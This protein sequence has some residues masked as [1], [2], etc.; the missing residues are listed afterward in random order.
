MLLK[1]GETC[2]RVERAQRVRVLIDMQAYFSALKCSMQ[3]A[4]HSLLLLGWAFD[5][6]TCLEPDPDGS[7]PV[8]DE[9]GPFIRNLGV[10][11]PDLDIRVLIWKS[12][13]PIAASQHF[14]PH[15]AR[16]CFDTTP[17]AF[18]LDE[19]VPLGACHHQKVVTIDDRVAFSGG[20]D[21]CV[22]RFDTPI[23]PDTDPRRIMPMDHKEHAPRHETM[24]VVD[25]AAAAA[26]ADLSR[27]RWRHA[28]DVRV[29]RP[30]PV[31][32]DPWPAD[33]EPELVDVP[34]G[35]SR[36]LPAWRGEPEVRESERLHLLSIAA[37][38]RCIYLENQ[39]IASPVIG[40]ALA[41][42]LAEPDGPEVVIISTEHAPSWFDKMTM[43]K[44][45]GAL[46]QQLQRADAHDRLHAFCP[47]TLGGKVIIVHS[48]V[49]VIDDCLL[50]VGSTNLNNRSL[51][52]D[53][54]V[55]L[56]FE[57]ETAEH[58]QAISRFLARTVGHFLGRTAEEMHEAVGGAGSLAR[59]IE[60]L[61]DGPRRRLRRIG[62]VRLGPLAT[63]IATYHLG[64]PAGVADAWRPWKR[65]RALH[66]DLRR[67]SPPPLPPLLTQS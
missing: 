19:T 41:A 23:H 66:K 65:R 58:R 64:D 27:E 62:P 60:R 55:D 49:S 32:H 30:P 1:P 16:K 26:L 43:D 5:P 31:A 46:L 36:T 45:R 47:E 54:E 44:T 20:G 18:R 4:Q 13:L 22:D 35:I 14:F 7:G 15:R 12:A 33:V 40:D 48:K 57:A 37:A 59:A 39:Y 3:K 25:G 34:M 6:L 42:R 10:E 56:A 63:L 38:K 24:V 50:R 17:V 67:L 51:G 29:K 52:F 11:K 28:T 8:K 53:T 61:D 9:A 21:I 2:W